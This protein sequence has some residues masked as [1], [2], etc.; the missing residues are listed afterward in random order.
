M[1]DGNSGD[2]LSFSISIAC[3]L[4]EVPSI[5]SGAG[6]LV[7]SLDNNRNEPIRLC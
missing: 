7:A 4:Y 6:A 5:I 2:A 3:E 1:N